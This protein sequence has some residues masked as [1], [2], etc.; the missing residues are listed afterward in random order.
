LLQ[1]FGADSATL[2]NVAQYKKSLLSK[3]TVDEIR[4]DEPAAV[5]ATQEIFKPGD[6]V[7]F[8]AEPGKTGAIIAAQKGDPES[9]YQVFHGGAIFTYYEPNLNR[10]PKYPC[11]RPLNQMLCMQR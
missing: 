11:G 10:R 7:S 3:L 9:R 4:S 6:I 8:K 2:N 1:T 5:A